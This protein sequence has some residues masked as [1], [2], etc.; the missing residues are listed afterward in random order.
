[1]EELKRRASEDVTVPVIAAAIKQLLSEKISAARAVTRP[2][3]GESNWK[4]FGR[5][6]NFAKIL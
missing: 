1:M 4:R 3:V 6:I 2:E 5:S